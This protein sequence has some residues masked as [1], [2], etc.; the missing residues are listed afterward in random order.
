M[1]RPVFK[2]LNVTGDV[3]LFEHCAAKEPTYYVGMQKF[4]A[5]HTGQKLEVLDQYHAAFPL[6]MQGRYRTIYIDTFAGTGRVL[7]SAAEEGP[8]LPGIES[9]PVVLEG[10]V[11]RALRAALSYDKYIFI[12]KSRRKLNTLKA[13]LS[14]QFAHLMDRCEFCCADA[15]EAIA[16]IC[17]ETDWDKYRAVVFLDPF[18]N[19]IAWET[20][21]AIARTKAADVWYLFPAGLGVWR[22][23]PKQGAIQTKAAQSVTR[24][25]GENAWMFL[26]TKKTTATNLFGDE[27]TT[28]SRN[29]TMEAVTDYM[30]HRLRTIFKGGVLD[31]RVFLGGRGAVRWYSLLFACANPRKRD[32]QLAHRIAGW[33]MQQA[34]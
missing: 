9:A 24:M 30:I 22:Q 26:F 16:K 11:P 34:K 19:Q 1:L 15:N 6:N 31:E 33:I 20:L 10:S 8:E 4:G 7:L 23:I 27:E 21:E 29:A 2:L 14:K 28:I 5:G 18:G 13:E 32:N 17:S 25:V 3:S 12:E